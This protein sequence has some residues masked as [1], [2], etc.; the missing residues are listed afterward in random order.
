MRT[1]GKEKRCGS[2][3]T[4][5]LSLPPP[6]TTNTIKKTRHHR[7]ARKNSRHLQHPTF[8]SSSSLHFFI[9]DCHNRTSL[10][11]PHVPACPLL[12]LFL[13]LSFFFIFLSF[14][15][16]LFSIP[17][18]FLSY[19]LLSYLGVVYR[20]NCEIPPTIDICQVS[21]PPKPHLLNESK[22]ENSLCAPPA[23]SFIRG[24]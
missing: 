3:R 5:H 9:R 20:S 10:M 16:F 7:V 24:S 6:L 19:P 21:S 13:I 22:N 12:F 15:P 1:Y 18:P 8:S 17:F 11:L 4:Y 2:V 23:C 14:F